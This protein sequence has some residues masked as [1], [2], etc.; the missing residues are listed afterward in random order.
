MKIKEI[1]LNTLFYILIC[2]MAISAI[3]KMIEDKIKADEKYDKKIEECFKQEPRTNDC[4]FVLW[5][6]EN[7]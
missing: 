5:R 4:E 3:S 1:L 6:Y 7:R 2:F